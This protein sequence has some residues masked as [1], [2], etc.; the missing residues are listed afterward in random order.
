MPEFEYDPRYHSSSLDVD[1]DTTYC[2]YW[3]N[4]IA[5]VV[6]CACDGFDWSSSRVF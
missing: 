3:E 2:V 5:V 1:A 4:G 6:S